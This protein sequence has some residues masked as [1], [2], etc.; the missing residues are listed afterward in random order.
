MAPPAAPPREPAQPGP[1]T[2]PKE[3]LKR[4]ARTLKDVGEVTGSNDQVARH[5]KASQVAFARGDLQEAAQLMR[6]ALSLAP[7]RVDIKTEHERLSRELAE[8][9]ANDYIVQAQFETKQGKWASAALTWSKVCE[10]RPQDAHAHRQA[11]FALF[12]VGGD[13]RSAQK[14]AQQAVFLA[15]TDVDARVLLAQIYLTIGLK[16]NAKRELDAAAKLDPENEMVKNLLS[17]LKSS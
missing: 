10:G 16:L 11:A 5:M 2:D 9:L 6:K 4:L 13:L 15:Q 8:K 3:L 12:K 14:Y 17:D 1:R 7:D